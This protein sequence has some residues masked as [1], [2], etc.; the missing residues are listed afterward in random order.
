MYVGYN[1]TETFV[2]NRVFLMENLESKSYKILDTSLQLGSLTLK[3]KPFFDDLI[4]DCL[5][6]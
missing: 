6:V 3:N 5:Y 1:R 2:M 4:A